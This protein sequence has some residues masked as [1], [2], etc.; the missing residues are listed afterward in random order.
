MKKSLVMLMV[1]V[2]LAV[3]AIPVFAARGVPPQPPVSNKGGLFTLAGTITA[4][5]GNVVTVKVVSGNPIARPYVGQNVALQTT[6]ITRFLLTTP[7][8]TVVITLADLQVGQNVS[9]QGKLTNGAWTADRITA[10]AKIIHP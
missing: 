9:A 4:I 8:G 1:V 5:D 10:G 3:S 7:T 6:A 2:L